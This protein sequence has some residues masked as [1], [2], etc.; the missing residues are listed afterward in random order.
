MPPAPL[1]PRSHSHNHLCTQVLN[2]SPRWTFTCFKPFETPPTPPALALV[3]VGSPSRP[4]LQIQTST[5]TALIIRTHP[6]QITSTLARESQ[7][8]NY[9][10]LSALAITAM[11]D[12]LIPDDWAVMLTA[13]PKLVALVETPDVA[14]GA[15]LGEEGGYRY[16]V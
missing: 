12:F 2:S 3:F 5:G 6:T 16:E 14:V 8:T 10:H 7:Q 11:W 4:Y 9:A 15:T 1:P 13:I